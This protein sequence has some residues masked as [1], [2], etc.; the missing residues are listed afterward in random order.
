MKIF[1][2]LLTREGSEVRGVREDLTSHGVPRHPRARPGGG[3]GGHG[4][5]SLAPTGGGQV[6]AGARGA[7][8]GGRH[9]CQLKHRDLSGDME[10]GGNWRDWLE[11]V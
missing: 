6:G 3:E 10:E 8:G 7:G 1:C 5:A 4:R 9:S 11:F 2:F